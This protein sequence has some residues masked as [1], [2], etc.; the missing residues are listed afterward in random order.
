MSEE[1]TKN[2]EEKPE[3]EKPQDQVLSQLERAE[4]VVEAQK[5][6][7]DRTEKLMQDRQVLATMSG[8]AEAGQIPEKPK[9]E[10]AVE[11]KNRIMEND[12][13]DGEG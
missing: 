12:L 9:E 2:E 5:V 10:T 8:Q 11:Y 3:D 6:E 7:N 4:K 13:K 1:E